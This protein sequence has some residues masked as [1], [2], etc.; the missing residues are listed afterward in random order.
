MRDAL[1]DAEDRMELTEKGLIEKVVH[2]AH[3]NMDHRLSARLIR[4]GVPDECV[5][6]NTRLSPDRDGLRYVPD[7]IVVLPDNPVP[8]DP[9][10]D[11]AGV[12]DLVVEILSEGDSE[13]ARDLEEKPRRYALRGI[14]N[15]WIADPDTD[16]VRWLRLGAAGAGYHGVWT[17][18]LAE[19]TLP[20]ELGI[21]PAPPE[22]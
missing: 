7:A 9:H 4:L 2:P 14:P 20:P 12:P 22:R 3:G 8:A 10:Q 11:Y 21:G 6:K 17:R 19:V 18:R 5:F 16:S 13:R 1:L 15:Y